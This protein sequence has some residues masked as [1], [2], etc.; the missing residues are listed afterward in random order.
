MYDLSIIVPVYNVEKYIVRCIDSILNQTFKNFELILVND[1]SEDASGSICDSYATKHFNIKVIHKKNGGL[2]TARNKGIDVAT[3]KYIGFVD[4]DDWISP[5]MF[6]TLFEKTSKNDYDIVACNLWLIDNKGHKKLYNENAV[7]KEYT[8]K[9]AMEEIFENKILTFSSCN[10]IYKINLFDKVRF[11]EG[12]I[13]EDMDISYKLI[14]KSNLIFYTSKPLY[15]YDYN[16]QS[17]LRKPFSL[18]RLDLYTVQ[19]N[20]YSFYKKEYNYISDK[21]YL[22]FFHH[23]ISLF[24]EFSL[25][26]KKIAKDYKYIIEF[27]KKI[28]KKLFKDKST[29]F[30]HKI[31]LFLAIISPE[32]LIYLLKNKARI[33]KFI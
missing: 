11:C 16:E 4:S 26:D 5:D 33:K 25:Y 20:M 15:Y 30:K 28:L 24:V 19:K 29:K 21:V 12:I 32:M 18:K 9:D 17:I 2:S 31:K 7:D 6:K 10:K 3:G 27:D 23:S 22:N 14:L 8:K 13:L 1:G